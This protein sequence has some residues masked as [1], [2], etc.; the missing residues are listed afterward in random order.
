MGCGASKEP[1]IDRN[2]K[3]APTSS[4]TPHSPREKSKER[5][6]LKELPP[7]APKEEGSIIILVMEICDPVGYNCAAYL[8]KKIQ[9]AT[10]PLVTDKDG[11]PRKVKIRATARAE[12]MEVA[13]QL[14]SM[15]IEVVILD[16]ENTESIKAALAGV[17]RMFMDLGYYHAS[18][19]DVVAEVLADH[20]EYVVKVS[21]LRLANKDYLHLEDEIIQS[22]IPYTLLR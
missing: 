5:A 16:Q 19:E 11:N 22:G 10:A 21:S 14:A 2:N 15:G 4:K 1:S 13:L 9:E 8:H 6:P 17:D 20:L 12:D 3:N 18:N 7:V